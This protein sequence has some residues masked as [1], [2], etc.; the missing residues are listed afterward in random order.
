MA[1]IEGYVSKKNIIRW[2]ENYGSLEAGDQIDD[3]QVVIV[4]S[5]PKQ[6]DGVS[7]GRLNKI[8]L[9]QAL[10]QLRREMSFSFY[11]VRFTYIRPILQKE[12]LRI[13]NVRR[14]VFIRGLEQGE[15]YLFRVINGGAA[16]EKERLEGLKAAPGKLLA[17][18]MSE[19]VDA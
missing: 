17:K 8:M 5:G 1:H 6:T 14:P 19:K 2:L 7:G 16:E 4:N 15:E 18:I 12:A 3:G 11:C 9:D 13:L 10:G